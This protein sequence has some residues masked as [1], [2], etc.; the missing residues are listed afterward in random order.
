[1]TERDAALDKAILKQ[2]WK[3][4]N[5]ALMQCAI[6]GI[7]WIHR[8]MKAE[9]DRERWR[10][11]AQKAETEIRALE[12]VCSQDTFFEMPKRKKEIDKSVVM[13]FVDVMN[14]RRPE[15]IMAWCRAHD[16]EILDA[17]ALRRR[18]DVEIKKGN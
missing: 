14:T 1:M 3:S 16:L 6:I 17:L 11:A 10:T 8:A 7:H 12:H 9:D 2:H 15:K 4:G 13:Q 5:V 18:L